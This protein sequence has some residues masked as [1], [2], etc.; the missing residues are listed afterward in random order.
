MSRF[1]L[2]ALLVFSSSALAQN[3]DPAT[4][5]APPAQD[6]TYQGQTLSG[7]APLTIQMPDG[8]E[9]Q[10]G[11][12]VEL[13]PV[14]ED[15]TPATVAAAPGLAA[16]TLRQTYTPLE[17]GYGRL[18]DGFPEITTVRGRV[19]AVGSQRLCRANRPTVS[20][21]LRVRLADTDMATYVLVAIQ[22]DEEAREHYLGRTVSIRAW[23][24][25]P[26]NPIRMART[27]LP[28]ADAPIYQA[29]RTDIVVW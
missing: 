26:D 18:D 17:D 16:F 25:S 4:G 23:K 20:R 8:R 3:Q 14:P 19:V 22:C 15:Q 12:Q 13:V 24:S 7:E 6:N 5:A 10:T 11:V 1:S 2:V 9:V 21:W 27:N 28:P 29:Y